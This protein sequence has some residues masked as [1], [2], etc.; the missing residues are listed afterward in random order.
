MRTGALTLLFLVLWGYI[1]ALRGVC[2][3]LSDSIDRVRPAVVQVYLKCWYSMQSEPL[4]SVG[5]GFLINEE[6]FVLTATHVVAPC[7]SAASDPRGGTRHPLSKQQ[8]L[9]GFPIA[10][11]M[12]DQNHTRN[13]FSYVE[14]QIVESEQQHDVAVL[15]L[16]QNPFRTT[17]K[18]GYT[19][20]GKEI[21]VLRPGIA[22]LS[23]HKV[24]KGESI[25]V[26]GYPLEYPALQTNAGIVA[27][28]QTSRYFDTGNAEVHVRLAFDFYIADM[29]VNHGN[30]GG[31][32]Y[33]AASGEVIGICSEMGL[34]PL[35]LVGNKQDFQ[36]GYN[37]GFAII[38]P[39][40][41]A[42]GLFA[43]HGIMI[44]EGGTANAH[45]FS[46]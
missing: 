12:T 9:I 8:L 40:R 15:K 13:N 23:T 5:T 36:R 32:V 30:S 38:V 18:S 28:T 25:A 41:Y 27:S 34:A 1:G 14:A 43:K 16:G 10:H 35:E 7:P 46:S 3:N 45:W 24:R 22:K 6:G 4:G 29:R 11:I 33:D 17:I 44:P 26:S 42:T 39:I 21:E 37:S 2:Q 20:N 19:S 31:P